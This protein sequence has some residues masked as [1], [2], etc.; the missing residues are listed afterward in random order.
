MTLLACSCAGPQH[1]SHGSAD[2]ALA[3]TSQPRSTDCES[4]S[5]GSPSQG[6]E[7]AIGGY[8]AADAI[9]AAPAPIAAVGAAVATV[10]VVGDAVDRLSTYVASREHRDQQRR[11]RDH[12]AAT[13]AFQRERSK[14]LT[15]DARQL[16]HL[17]SESARAGDCKRV[18]QLEGAVDDQDPAVHDEVFLR[19]PEIRRCLAGG[20]RTDAVSVAVSTTRPAVSPERT[21]R[22][23]APAMEAA[24][25]VAATLTRTA[26]SRAQR[27]DC[28]MVRMLG[29]RI[30]GLDR[31]YY[32]RVFIVDMTIAACLK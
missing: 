22:P 19:D 13:N 26:H 29:E 24:N 1:T 11:C 27:G 7:V 15:L 25:P 9:R 14:A 21:L 2:E 16:T 8:V 18:R 30:R 5:R 20:P 4:S 12:D 32:Q 6:R 28:A 23:W 10:F 31:V 17:A 3:R